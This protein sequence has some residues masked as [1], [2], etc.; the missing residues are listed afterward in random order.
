MELP[1][2]LHDHDREA[3]VD[4]LFEKWDAVFFELCENLRPHTEED[5]QQQ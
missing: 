2:E 4:R 5:A 1:E 3:L